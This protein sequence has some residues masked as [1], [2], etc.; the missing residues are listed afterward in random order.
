MTDINVL[1]ACSQLYTLCS[2]LSLHVFV[3][4]NIMRRVLFTH[5]KVKSRVDYRQVVHS[6]MSVNTFHIR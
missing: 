2:Y 1:P 4:R 6:S 5:S 3:C